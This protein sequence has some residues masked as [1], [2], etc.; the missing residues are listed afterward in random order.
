MLDPPDHTKWRRVLGSYFSPGRVE[1]LEEEQRKFARDLIEKFRANGEV[2]FYEAFAGVFPTTIFLQI[3]G[4]PIDKLDDFMIWEAAILHATAEED[5]DHSKA[6]AAMMEV[7]GYFQGLIT[8][9]REQPETRGDDI[10]S[11]AI[12]WKI[13]GEAPKDEDLLSCMLLLFM[14][15]LDTVAAQLS[16]AFYHLANHDE[17]RQRLIDDPSQ[18]PHAVEE[19][20]RAYP[21][22]QTS[23]IATSDVDFR[24]CPVK[25]GDMVAFSLGMAGR[26]PN[27][28]ENSREVDLD[29]VN[30]RHISFGAGPHRCLGSHLARQEMVVALQEW[31]KLIPNYRVSDPDAVIEHSAGVYSIE[32][33]PLAWDV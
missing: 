20:M 16:Y 4:L 33:L 32:C 14:A 21:I 13:D 7:M 18:V 30:P 28:Y 23:R 29:R 1:R 31:H 24:G 10:V 19:L 3:L 15:G 6:F 26:D 8:E 5:P 22:V 17:D 9:R 2:D 11:H 12:E 25:E 27:A